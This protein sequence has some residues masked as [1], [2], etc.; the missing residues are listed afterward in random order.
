MSPS[1]WQ[2]ILV[3]AVVLVLF[4]PKRIP[5]IGRSLGEALRGFKKGLDGTETTEDST[6][7]K[8]KSENVTQAKNETDSKKNQDAKTSN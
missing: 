5:A 1:F 4:G 8:V 6:T 2:I 3:L 7:Q